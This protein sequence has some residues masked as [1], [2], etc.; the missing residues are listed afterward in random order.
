MA[1]GF[2]KSEQIF[3]ED[4][5]AGFDPNNVT[6]RNCKKYEPD[7]QAVERSGLT[8]RRPIPM[9]AEITR[10]LDVSA[11]YKD[12]LELTVPSSLAQNDIKNHAFTLN[13]LD[14]NDSTRRKRAAM[15][16]SQGLAAEVDTDVSNRVINYGS[17]VATETGDFTNYDALSKGETQLME[18]EV[19]ATVLRSLIL[20]PRMARKMAND[21]ASRATDNPRDRSAYER[22]A[23]PPVGGFETMKSNVLTSI[24]GNAATDILVSGAGQFKTPTVF[25]G[26]NT[27]A[28]DNRYQT[29]TT[30]SVAAATLKNGDAFT[31][32]GVFAVGMIT[33]KN[34]GQLQT[35]RVVSGGGTTT[36]TISPAIIPL[37]Q[38]G[39]AF[40]KYANVTAT[41]ANG[42]AITIL[43]TDSAQ[44]SIF[45]AE[46]AVEIFHG[47]L[48]VD[49][50]GQ[51]V[52]IMRE[53]TDSGIEIIFAKQGNV[54]DFSAK[55]RLTCWTSA[56]VLDPQMAG[57]YLPNQ[58]V[59]FG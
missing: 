2:S 27:A 51:G 4:V 24:T 20:N 59:A 37:D 44:P 56:N 9:R 3:F 19:S 7:M 47:K 11:D 46:P 25:D 53:V 40:Q 14:L 42:A 1:N 52:S 45:F 34:T 21:L 23:L 31:I 5:L 41:P 18:R 26:T 58:N 8:V 38:A 33:K 15:A 6:S 17:L 16:A 57:I 28:A 13:A 55:Y 10:G 32:A 39:T 49:D 54:D 29:L 50:L 12:V 36:P 43:N 22:S 35:F 30:S 48:A